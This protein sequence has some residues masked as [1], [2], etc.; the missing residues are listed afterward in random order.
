VF[1]VSAPSG[2]GKTTVC[3]AVVE[4][5]P[6][7][8][9]SVSHTTRAPRPGE[10][11]GVEYHFVSPAEFRR[12]A[13]EGAFLEYAQYHENLY[14]TSWQALEAPRAAGRDV[15]LEIE[16]QGGA[17]VRGRLPEARLVFLV[18]PSF[19]DL[20]KRLRG[21]GT[22]GEEV[23]QKRLAIAHQELQAVVRYDYVVVNDDL[24][25]AVEAV[26][27]IVRAERAGRGAEVI[28]RHGR[29]AVLAGLRGRLPI[30]DL[31]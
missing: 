26:L 19:D 13:E 24:S 1:V 11:D 21:R 4:R 25:R 27:E 9:V 6:R 28:G 20:E 22:D 23:I 12:L 10:R 16:V 29:A 8:V 5:D 18:P 3:R 7:I 30:P 31:A 2:T 15:L 17:Q 14:G